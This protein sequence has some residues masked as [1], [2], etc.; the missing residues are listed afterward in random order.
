MP[1]TAGAGRATAEECL[2]ELLRLGERLDLVIAAE[3]PAQLSSRR[4]FAHGSTRPYLTP[5]AAAVQARNFLEARR[6]LGAAV[7]SLKKVI[8]RHLA[9]RDRRR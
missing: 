2:I 7:A 3:A 5:F 8:T 6:I 1:K 9:I 4:G